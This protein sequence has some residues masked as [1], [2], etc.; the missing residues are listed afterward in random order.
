M[1]RALASLNNEIFSN[2][3][4]SVANGP[5]GFPIRGRCLLG[6]ARAPLEMY[7]RAVL[8][9]ER[10]FSLFLHGNYNRCCYCRHGILC[11]FGPA[12]LALGTPLGCL[13]RRVCASQLRQHLKYQRLSRRRSSAS[14]SLKVPPTS[15]AMLCKSRV[16]FEKDTDAARA[17]REKHGRKPQKFVSMVT[18]RYRM[19]LMGEMV[20]YGDRRGDP[21]FI[22]L[23]IRI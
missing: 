6:V 16:R 2:R 18:E 11:H 22:C 8:C 13:M 3:V 17:N 23:L 15:K 9:N 10:D 4:G 1:L 20:E 5:P 14:P 12:L 21:V 7:S 19:C